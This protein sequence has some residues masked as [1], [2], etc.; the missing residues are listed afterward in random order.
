MNVILSAM[1][2]ILSVAKDLVD[3]R[4]L[5]CFASLSMTSSAGLWERIVA[6][7]PEPHGVDEHCPKG[8]S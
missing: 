1:H 3:I 2:V 8:L 5:R 4:G 7:L 6:G